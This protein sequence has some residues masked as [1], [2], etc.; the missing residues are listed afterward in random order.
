MRL[1]ALR[2]ADGL[3]LRAHHQLSPDV[4]KMAVQ[5]NEAKRAYG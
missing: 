3:R 2:L 5:I 1:P 4:K